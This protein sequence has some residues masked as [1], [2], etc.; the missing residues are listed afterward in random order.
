[1][2]SGQRVTVQ[3]ALINP[4]YLV[5][6][7]RGAVYGYDAVGSFKRDEYGCMGSGQNFI[8]P[9]LDNLVSLHVTL[10]WGG[11]RLTVCSCNL[12]RA[13]IPQ[14]G[15]KNRLDEKK[16][17]SAEEVVAIVKDIFI[18]ATERDIYT[19]DSVEIKVLKRGSVTTEVFPLKT[20]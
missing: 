19:G 17:L 18:T 9:I 10:L 14:I 20:D 13:N 5:L 4:I 15:H 1:M 7:G 2:V 12:L 3:P 16:P 8:M 6:T 11:V